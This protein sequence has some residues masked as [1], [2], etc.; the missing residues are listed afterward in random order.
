MRTGPPEKKKS[1]DE[2]IDEAAEESFPASDPPSWT[3]GRD[4]KPQEEDEPT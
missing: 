3:L 2:E 1:E 4:E